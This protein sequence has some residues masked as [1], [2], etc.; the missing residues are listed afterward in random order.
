MGIFEQIRGPV[1]SFLDQLLASTEFSEQI[2]YRKW[3]G[4]SFDETLKHNVATY[5]E[6]PIKTARMRHNSRSVKVAT[7]DIQ[8]G[9]EVFIFKSIDVPEGMSLKDLIVD[10]TGLIMKVKAIDNIFDIA[11]AVTVESGG[12][13]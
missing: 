11:H 8:V 12:V 13:Q 10:S 3:T 6:T 5:D 2:T 9:D 1:E 7:A 4:Q